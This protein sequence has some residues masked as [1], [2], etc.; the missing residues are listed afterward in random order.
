MKFDKDFE[1]DV[2][3][4]CMRSTA[5][6]KRAS[7]L[8]EAHH[9]HSPQHGWLWG[10]LKSVWDLNRE[11]AT[12]SLLVAKAKR[13]YKDEEEREAVIELA[14]RIGARRPIA[15]KT[16][17]EELA[18]FSKMVNA[19]I[20]LEESA[21][22]LEKGEVEKAYEPLQKLVRRN[23]DPHQYTHEQWSERFVERLAD[24][25]YRREHPEDFPRVPTG[26]KRL[27][28]ILSGGLEVTE[29]GMVLG[30]TGRGKSIML[31]NMAY[32]AILRGI[33]SVYFSMEMPAEQIGRRCDARWLKMSYRK[34]KEFDFKPSELREIEAK[35]R[36]FKKRFANM[37]HIVSTPLRKCNM[38]VVRAALDD[39]QSDYDF[40][41]RAIFLDSADHM[42]PVSLT[43]RED[44]RLKQAAV[45]WEIADFAGEEGYA[46]W[47]STHAGRDWADKTAEAESAGESYDK[48]RIVDVAISINKPKKKKRSKVMSEDEDGDEDTASRKISGKYME[49]RLSKYRDGDSAI[50]IPIDADFA[51]MY[52]TEIDDEDEGGM[53][54]REGHD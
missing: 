20:A 14:A 24:R 7:R 27:D 23:V 4:C 47:T 36:R 28:R 54:K 17:L 5:Y 3:A 38:D 10:A 21:K 49:M 52:L 45:Y 31:A 15:G 53:P 42:T 44:Y 33:P 48:A 6:L 18:R 1:E 8:L 46:I 43:G 13:D 25:K 9:F 40:R 26:F 51:R 16:T 39:L 30:T 19:Q 35:R 22:M 11:R 2:L 37:F 50:T 32:S 12:G 34:L 41:P 29:V